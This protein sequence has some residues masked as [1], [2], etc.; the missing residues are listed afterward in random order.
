M[1]GVSCS[2]S[3][4]DMICNSRVS[5]LVGCMWPIAVVG[6]KDC[7]GCLT[8]VGFLLIKLSQSG[9]DIGC[10]SVLVWCRGKSQPV[11]VLKSVRLDSAMI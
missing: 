8:M 1:G 2:L 10:V 4:R 5:L 11:R 6:C 9:V 3:S 7:S